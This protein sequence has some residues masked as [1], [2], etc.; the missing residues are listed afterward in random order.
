MDSLIKS[1]TYYI[2]LYVKLTYYNNIFQTKSPIIHKLNT[3]ISHIKM[4]RLTN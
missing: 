2:T 1:I 4:K 3:S